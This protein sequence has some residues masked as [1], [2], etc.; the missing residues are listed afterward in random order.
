M[1]KPLLLVFKAI[2]PQTGFDKCL[3]NSCFNRFITTFGDGNNN[4]ILCQTEKDTH[5]HSNRYGIHR[6]VPVMENAVDMA[7]MMLPAF[8]RKIS[9]R[10][11]KVFYQI[12]LITCFH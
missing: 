1:I 10:L 2:G 7:G 3:K 9:I 6:D 11:F 5:I 4:Y 12:I 8:D